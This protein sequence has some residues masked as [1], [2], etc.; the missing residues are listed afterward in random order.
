[1]KRN[2]GIKKI[3]LSL[4]NIFSTWKAS[5]YLYKSSRCTTKRTFYGRSF[6]ENWTISPESVANYMWMGKKIQW[7]NVPNHFR[8]AKWMWLQFAG[9][10][11]DSVLF[12]L[13]KWSQ[14]ENKSRRQPSFHLLYWTNKWQKASIIASRK[15]QAFIERHTWCEQYFYT[16][17]SVLRIT[18]RNYQ[19]RK[20][21]DY[22]PSQQ[23][24]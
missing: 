2:R 9:K 14:R 6:F 23:L 22:W 7:H 5:H 4:D 10:E 1:M 3:N 21:S 8:M 20:L 12:V 11:L 18:Q 15:T 17:R 16:I 24:Y 19:F 13:N